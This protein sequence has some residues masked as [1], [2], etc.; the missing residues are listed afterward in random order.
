[1]SGQITL[2]TDPY[3]NANIFGNPITDT[4]CHNGTQWVQLIQGFDN[5]LY[6]AMVI[7]IILG[8]VIGVVAVILG[9]WWRNRDN[10]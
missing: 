7:G 4:I 5:A 2:L 1:M 3:G 9:I 10:P 8:F 6:N